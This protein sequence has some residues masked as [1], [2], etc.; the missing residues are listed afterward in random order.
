MHFATSACLKH[1]RD[2]KA[3]AFTTSACLKHSR[4]GKACVFTTSA[5]LTHSRDGKACV[6]TTSACLTHSRDGKACVHHKRML[7]TL[8]RRE[9]LCIHHK[10]MLETL[11][12]KNMCVPKCAFFE[13]V[14]WTLQTS[15][16][17]P[18]LHWNEAS[19]GTGE[20]LRGDVFRASGCCEIGKLGRRQPVLEQEP[21]P[22]RGFEEGRRPVGAEAAGRAPKRGAASCNLRA[23]FVAVPSNHSRLHHA[24]LQSQKSIFLRHMD[25]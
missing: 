5:C 3:C 21:S 11:M 9:S 20:T 10:C 2:G 7:E 12:T 14:V 23:D 13:N 6:F 17:S 24:V 22:V 16:Q 8:S 4:D 18:F 19:D 25:G 1:S 15:A